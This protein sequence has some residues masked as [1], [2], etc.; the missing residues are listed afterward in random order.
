MLEKL[1]DF[2]NGYRGPR[3]PCGK[4]H[5]A[6]LVDYRSKEVQTVLSRIRV[7]R[8]YYHCGICKAGMF[9]KE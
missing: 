7:R 6:D 4:G 2:D 8:A 5:Q 3:V 1:L 9:P